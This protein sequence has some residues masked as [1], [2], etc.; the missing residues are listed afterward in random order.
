MD[1]R[2]ITLD[3]PTRRRP[4]RALGPLFGGHEKDPR[5][6]HQ[7]GTQ[8]TIRLLSGLFLVGGDCAWVDGDGEDSVGD[9]RRDEFADG[10]FFGVED[11][12]GDE[13]GRRVSLRSEM[14]RV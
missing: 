5:G 13:E 7:R 14:M 3:L 6:R 11:A 4:K 2:L 8:Q 12:K 10:E 9:W 1:H